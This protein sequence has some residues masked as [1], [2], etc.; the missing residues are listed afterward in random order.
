M[1]TQQEKLARMAALFATSDSN[2][3][4]PSNYY[5]FYDMNFNE[6]ATVRL[7]PDANQNNPMEFTVEKLM[8]NLTI[9]GERRSVPCMKMYDKN[10]DCPICKV[11]SAFYKEEGKDSPNGKKYWRKKQHILQ[12]L[13]IDDPLAPNPETGE[14]SEG[15]IRYLNFGFQLFSVIKEAL[16]GGDLEALPWDVREGYDFVIKKTQQ[17]ENAKYDLGSK[18]VRK[19][20]SLTDDEIALVEEESIDLSTLIP[21]QMDYDKMESMLNASLTGEHYED[22]GNASAASTPAATPAAEAT[23]AATPAVESAPVVEEAAQEAAPVAAATEAATPAATPSAEEYA[24]KGNDVLE[25]IRNRK[26]AEA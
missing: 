23:P 5:R 24:D 20:S 2:E 6:T 13:V 14:N 25:M 17:G 21:A 12:C 26:S 19:Q 18:F 15:K 8:H 16:T 3:S 22:G 11:S 10:A 1:S 4:R 9:N 7:L